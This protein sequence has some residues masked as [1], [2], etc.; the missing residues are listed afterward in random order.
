M[1]FRET[2]PMALEAVRTNKLRSF[3]T[4][5]GIVAGVASIIAVMTGISVVQNTIEQEL[6]VLGTQTFQVQ[7]WPAGNFGP[8]DVNWRKIQARKPIEVEHS[9]VVREKVDTVDLVG[10]ELWR[11]GSVVKFM[12]ESTNPNLSVVGGDPQ[13][14]PNNTHYVGLGRNLSEEDVRVHRKVAVIGFHIAQELFPFI[15]PLGKEIKLDGRKYTVIGV[16]DE[17]KS[18]MGGR[19][20]DYVLIPV[21]TWIDAYGL[22]DSDGNR[23]RSVN[24]TVRALTPALLPDAIEEVRAV[25]RVARGVPPGEDDDFDIFTNDSQIRSF[26]KATLGVKVGAFVIGIVA[27]VVAGIGIMNIMLVSVTERTRE[28]GIR[29]ALGARRRDILRQ[30]LLEAILLCNVG[31]AIGVLVGFGLG[32][33][34]TIFTGFAVSVPMEWAVNGLVFCTVVGL[35]FGMWPAMKASKLPPIEAL[36]WE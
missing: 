18:A 6:S 20:D 22:R 24:M 30:F 4:L 23:E 7:K 19:F 12:G 25:L 10:S 27:L 2:F 33:I 1:R 31:G 16:F 14:P 9:D 36:R 17:K 21:T 8:N 35:V 32:N 34:V 11:F 29:K 28:I 5:V 26:N 3:L 15:D 13:Y